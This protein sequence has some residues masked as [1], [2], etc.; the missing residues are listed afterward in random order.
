MCVSTSIKEQ[1]EEKKENKRGEEEEEKAE[2][3][4]EKAEEEEEKEVKEDLVGVVSGRQNWW[5]LLS[6]HSVE[7]IR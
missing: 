4:E 2:E 5:G 7:R 1:I 3:E 6:F